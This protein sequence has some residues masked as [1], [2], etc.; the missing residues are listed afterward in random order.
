MKKLTILILSF[1]TFFFT[2]C[3]PKTPPTNPELMNTSTPEPI[4]TSTWQTYTNKTFGLTFQYPQELKLSEQFEEKNN[5]TNLPYLNINLYS[6]KL[7]GSIIVNTPPTGLEGYEEFARKTIN[8][9]K[10]PVELIFANQ[11]TD[12]PQTNPQQML[13]G[14]FSQQNNSYLFLFDYSADNQTEKQLAEKILETI[15]IEK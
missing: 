13:Y 9:N 15:K 7:S 11:L 14:S 3:A 12:L 8:I 10:T 6:E 2:G 5:L 1:F 4:S